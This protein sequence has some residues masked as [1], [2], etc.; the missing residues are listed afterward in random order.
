MMRML[1]AMLSAVLLTTLSAAAH[2]PYTSLVSPDGRLCCSGMDCRERVVRFDAAA[3]ELEINI[4][5]KWWVATDPRWYIGAGPPGLPP[6]SW[7]G[8]QMPT[9]KTPRCTMGGGAS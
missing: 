6:D 1:F 9:D 5:G 8:C 2:E 3:N 7:S 4:D